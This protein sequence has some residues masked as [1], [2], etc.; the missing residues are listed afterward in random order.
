MKGIRYSH[1]SVHIVETEGHPYRAAY[2]TWTRA[3]DYSED[4]FT[5][6]ILG[7]W[8]H[9]K[10]RGYHGYRDFKQ[11]PPLTNSILGIYQPL[12]QKWIDRAYSDSEAKGL[13]LK[14]TK[15][16][17]ELY[18]KLPE[19]LWRG[20][21]KIKRI[22]TSRWPLS[23]HIARP[24]YVTKIARK[25]RQPFGRVFF[26]NNNLGSPAFE[27]ALFRGHCAAVNIL[28]RMNKS[29]KP[30]KWTRCPID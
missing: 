27:E 12:P 26:A 25:L 22:E 4:D 13:A 16:M 23:V 30:V 18:S 29:Y 10:M 9:P 1:Y 8:M 15:R 5:D 17:Y 28:K 14:S 3:S 2:D 7:N 24:G 21:L 11:D 6:L 19:H 20:P